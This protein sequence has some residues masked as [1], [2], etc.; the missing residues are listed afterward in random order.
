MTSMQK[1]INVIARLFQS[2]DSI[3]DGEINYSR[4]HEKRREYGRRAHGKKFP[5]LL[6]AA[7]LYSI[8][9]I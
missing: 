7:K 4:G 8:Y 6:S 1:I 3:L 2:E 9:S 5:F